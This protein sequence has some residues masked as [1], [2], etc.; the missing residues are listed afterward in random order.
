MTEILGKDKKSEQAKVILSSETLHIEQFARKKGDQHNFTKLEQDIDEIVRIKSEQ[1]P[2]K[3]IS[4]NKNSSY[5]KGRS[6]KR[7]EIKMYRQGDIL[8]KKIDALPEGLKIK[9]DNIVAG[10]EGSAHVHMLVNGELFQVE[11]SDQKYIRTYEDTRSIHEEHLP[12]KLESGNYE[13]VR[14]REYLG[15]G[16]EKR[17]RFVVD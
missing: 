3:F 7:S 4:Q 9:S 12:I 15:P 10:G 14:Q 16:L 8:F 1:D 2:F 11:Q 13:V 17:E 5:S 6:E